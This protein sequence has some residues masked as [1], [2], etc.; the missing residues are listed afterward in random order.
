MALQVNLGGNDQAFLFGA[1]D[2]GGGTAKFA[3]AAHP[4]FDKYQNFPVLHD[5]VDF[6][7]LAA[8]VSFQQLQSLLL[9][10]GQRLVFAG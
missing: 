1:P 4:D 10:V 7:A 6:T 5:Q 8:E 3:V 9:Q 2:T